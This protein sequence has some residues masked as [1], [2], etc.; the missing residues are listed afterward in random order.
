MDVMSLRRCIDYGGVG[1][2]GYSAGR[3]EHDVALEGE[4]QVR[5]KTY[6]RGGYEQLLQETDDR[7]TGRGGPVLPEAEDDPAVQGDRSR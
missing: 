6:A 7:F 1:Q 3:H 4:M 2:S 5:N